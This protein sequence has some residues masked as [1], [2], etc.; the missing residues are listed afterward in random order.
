MLLRTVWDVP[1]AS[2]KKE[3]VLDQKQDNYFL[4]AS[5]KKASDRLALQKQATAVSVES[6]TL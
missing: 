1:S 6:R 4:T 5:F 3:L 2:S